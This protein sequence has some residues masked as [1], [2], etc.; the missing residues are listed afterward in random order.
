M[1]NNRHKWPH[2]GCR[3]R[4]PDRSTCCRTESDAR[5]GSDTTEEDR[6]LSFFSLGDVNAAIRPP[7]DR[8][9]DKVSRH[10]GASRRRLFAQL[11]K[12]ALKMVPVAPLYIDTTLN[13]PIP[14]RAFL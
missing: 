3:D 4:R 2:H 10:L 9:N 8:L 6:T 11:D 13:V 14:L 7:L 12:P 1:R 5:I